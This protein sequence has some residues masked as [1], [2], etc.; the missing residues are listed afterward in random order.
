MHHGE[1]HV[2]RLG[3]DR[4][5]DMQ[6][7]VVDD[8]DDG[9][10]SELEEHRRLDG[11]VSESVLSGRVRRSAQISSAAI[12]R[13]QQERLGP[14]CRNAGTGHQAAPPLPERDRRFT[15]TPL[16]RFGWAGA[17]I[18]NLELDA[19]YD[20]RLGS[21]VGGSNRYLG[22]GP[23][24]HRWFI[25]FARAAGDERE[26]HDRRHHSRDSVSSTDTVLSHSP[27]HPRCH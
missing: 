2:G 26:T 12:V 6:R 27:R 20:R 8:L 17:L 10:R 22:L 25:G 9:V 24:G 1:R 18:E 14:E 23:I 5:A 4:E 15:L 13:P 21:V 19:L 16:T 3:L 7:A 11:G